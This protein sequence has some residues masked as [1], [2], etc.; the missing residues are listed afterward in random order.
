M[1]PYVPFCYIFH[2]FNAYKSWSYN[3]RVRLKESFLK[4]IYKTS[5]TFQNSTLAI[6]SIYMFFPACAAIQI[7][8]FLRLLFSKGKIQYFVVKLERFYLSLQQ[9]LCEYT[10]FLN[11][12]PFPIYRLRPALGKTL[13]CGQVRHMTRQ[14]IESAKGHK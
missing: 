1:S 7:L 9:A 14:D 13:I 4:T 12:K 11:G 6:A 2:H 5:W 8:V 10:Q 3:R